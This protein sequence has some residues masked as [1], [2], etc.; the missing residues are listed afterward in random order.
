MSFGLEWSIAFISCAFEV[1]PSGNSPWS[2]NDTLLSSL[3]S[4]SNWRL[5]KRNFESH[6][7][8][9]RI[10]SSIVAILLNTRDTNTP[11]PTAHLQPA[12]LPPS[13]PRLRQN[14]L[15]PP[16]PHRPLLLLRHHPP[17]HH[18]TRI[19]L[20][21]HPV[22]QRQNARTHRCA[23]AAI[24]PKKPLSARWL[25]KGRNG[26]QMFTLHVWSGRSSR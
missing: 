8:L 19:Q 24:F 4:S 5:Q 14:L 10:N 7:P 2:C 6:P 9:E 17:P 25:R 16:L 12:H 22:R 11:S 26:G 21:P 13:Q 23:I 3:S 15:P 1:T 20:P 18:R